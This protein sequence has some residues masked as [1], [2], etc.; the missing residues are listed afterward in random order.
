MP[1]Q[2][3]V[4]PVLR[5]MLRDYRRY[6]ETLWHRPADRPNM[7]F[8]GSGRGD[9]GNEGVR[10]QANTALVYALLYRE[11][12]RTFPV[13]ERVDPALRYTAAIHT[14]GTTTGTDGKP[15]GNS[16]QSAMW[17]GNLG[18][19]AFLVRDQLTP[20]TLRAVERVVVAEA[21]RFIDQ[22]APAMTPG[23]TKSEENAWNLT[24]SSSAILLLPGHAH[25]AKWHET[26]LRY[27]FNTLSVAADTT[28]ARVVDGRPLRQWI[29][30]VQL[31]PDFTLEN[32]GFFHPVYAMVGP[33]TNAQAAVAYRFA[34]RKIPDALRHNVLAEWKMLQSIALADGEW[35]YPQGLDW[36]LHDY[37]H[38]HYWTMLATLYR[39]PVAALLERRM[40]GYARRRQQINGDGSFVGVSGSLGFAREA[41]QAERVAFALMMH[42]QFGAPPTATN[43]DWRRLIAGLPPVRIFERAG[44]VVHRTA[45]GLFS[46]SWK[47]RLMGLAAPDSENTP[48]APYVTTPFTESLTGRFVVAEQNAGRAASFTVRRHAAQTDRNGFVIALDADTNDGLLRQEIAVATAAPGVLAYVDR[49]R[50][51]RAVTIT[52]E[53]GLSVGVENDEV[54]GNQRQVHTSGGRT[55]MTAGVQRDHALP[56]R[57]ANVD[58]R[59]GLVSA[60]DASL[61]YRAAGKPNRAGAREDLLIGSFRADPRSFSA[62][63]VVAERA[64]LL[65]PNASP[66][67]TAKIASGLRVERGRGGTVLRFAAG[68]GRRHTLTLTA[69]GTVLWNGRSVR[70][71]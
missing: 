20:Q 28:S 46:F 11:G 3:E 19:A 16:W 1:P 63:A 64:G 51:R 43:T 54:S 12:D 58:G 50:A 33:A 40:A 45:R 2:S 65:L 4:P 70:P 69:D 39:D 18:F 13:A 31:Y 48:N 30:G 23:D 42:E 15:W 57:W 53:R 47:N 26:V 56:G 41:V 6:A 29:T 66:E 34:G 52:E 9:G 22:P 24:A 59:L 44:F 27:G 55:E 14:T 68:D 21:D 8:W 38:L 49:V 5:A 7:G 17:A 10:A 32:H 62:D 67:E 61:L 60:S 37:E 35:L 36:D 25:A 71:R